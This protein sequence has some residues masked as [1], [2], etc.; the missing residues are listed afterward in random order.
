MD[1]NVIS[2]LMRATPNSLVVAW[3]DR[4][5]RRSIWTTA[6]TIMELHQCIQILAPGRRRTALH[7]ELN[8]VVAENISLRDAAN[9]P[10][11]T[12]EGRILSFD[13]AAAQATASI[14]AQRK[15]S[16][17]S[18]ELRDSMIA[19]SVMSVGASLATRNTCHFDNLSP[20]LID[21]WTG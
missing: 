20:A 21:P 1:T 4:Q 2:Q 16:G 6:I 7:E 18:G 12:I 8:R 17:R 3:L 10:I 15:R 14:L 13:N 9:R 11:G 19:G 5:P